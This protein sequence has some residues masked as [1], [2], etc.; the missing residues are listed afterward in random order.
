VA[1]SQ[2]D[3][4]ADAKLHR[5]ACGDFTPEFPLEWALKD[6]DLAI[7]AANGTRLPMLRPLS[8][9]WRLA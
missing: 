1:A 5:I 7:E 2:R 4:I 9:Q 8:R 6:V 3:A